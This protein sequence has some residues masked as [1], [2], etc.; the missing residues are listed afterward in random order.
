MKNE[1]IVE[2]NQERIVKYDFMRIVFIMMTL[3]VHVV[4]LSIRPTEFDV[5][6]YVRVIFNGFFLICN[7]LFFMLSGRLNLAKEFTKKE[8]YI[9]FYKKKFISILLPFF[10][11]SLILYII[12]YTNSEFN[13][14]D[15]INRFMSNS[16]EPDGTLWF[17]YP[18]I[19]IMLLSPFYSKMLHYLQFFF[20]YL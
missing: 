17:I 1:N 7:P 6:Y 20:Y 3:G 18:F 15:F 14:L 10:I 13:F 9:H 19:G 16:I 11:I 8:D 2:T 12:L 5:H 4:A